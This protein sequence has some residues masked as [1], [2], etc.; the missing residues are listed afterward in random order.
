MSNSDQPK[1]I[2]I[3]DLFLTR[4]PDKS[5]RAMIDQDPESLCTVI[6]EAD[7]PKRSFTILG[8]KSKKL[9]SEGTPSRMSRESV[10]TELAGSIRGLVGDGDINVLKSPGAII[11]KA[12]AGKLKEVLQLPYVKAIRPNRRLPPIKP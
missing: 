7:L 10:L 11:V 4:I 12:N 9:V 1:G 2:P 8:N 3:T 6:V 5:L